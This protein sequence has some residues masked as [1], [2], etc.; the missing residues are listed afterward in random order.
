MDLTTDLIPAAPDLLPAVFDSGKNIEAM[1]AKVEARARSET[2]DVTTEEGRKGIASLARKVSRSKTAMQAIGDP[3]AKE[4]REKWDALNVHRREVVERLDKLRD[5]VKQ[6]LTDWRAAEEARF[7]AHNDRLEALGAFKD[8]TATL[9][10]DQIQKAIDTLDVVEISEKWEEFEVEAADTKGLSLA[11]L[12]RILAG[13]QEAEAREAELEELRREKIEREAADQRR[14]AD[15]A[16]KR[17]ELIAAEAATKAAEAKAATDI[18][19]ER[20]R[21]DKE[22]KE[23]NHRAEDAATTERNRIEAAAEAERQIIAKREAD[24]EHRKRIKARTCLAIIRL[25][26]GVEQVTDSAE[27]IV[28]AIGAGE[29]PHVTINY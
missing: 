15:E 22:V 5:E 2:H 3:L 17:R 25:I 6:P 7:A 4:A 9:G 20:D 13:S 12:R 21:A 24:Q 1:I 26:A 29:I 8:Y 11:H 28:E 18:E 14:R 10:S 27:R 16:M 23:A 19:A